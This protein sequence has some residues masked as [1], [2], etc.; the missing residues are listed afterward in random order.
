MTHHQRIITIIITIIIIIII[1][2]II[3]IIIIVIIIIKRHSEITSHTSHG[4]K[5]RTRSMKPVRSAPPRETVEVG[6]RFW[7]S[8][9]FAV[10]RD[11]LSEE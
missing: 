9:G 4:H 11:M 7:F 10:H 8:R 1:I 3:T 5:T 6:F 2:T